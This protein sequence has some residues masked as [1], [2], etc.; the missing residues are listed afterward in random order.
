[1]LPDRRVF[2]TKWRVEEFIQTLRTGV[3]PYKHQLAE[4]MPWRA[5]AAFGSDSDL[6]AMYAYLHALGPVEAQTH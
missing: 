1:M 6:T 2:L 4:G 3:D 5:I